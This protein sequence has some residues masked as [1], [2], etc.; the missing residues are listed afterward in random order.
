MQGNHRISVLYQKE[1][2]PKGSSFTIRKFKE[3]PYTVIDLV[4]FGTINLE[5]AAYLWMLVEA[6]MSFIVIGPTGSGKT[7]IL[8]AITGLVH[9]DY[10]IFSVE[11]V[12]EIN[13]NHE[14]WFTLIS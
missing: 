3:D 1:I 6:K 13:I 10:K 7:T 2:T 14:N 8:N 5:I 4:K 11:D 9:P 12:A